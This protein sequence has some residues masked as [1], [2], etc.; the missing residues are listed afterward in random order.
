MD[1]R[2]NGFISYRHSELDMYVAKKIHKGLETFKVP[3]AVAKAT[4]IKK[5]SRVFRD[6]EELP[7]GSDLGDNI[8]SAIQSSEFLIVICSPRTP[9]SEWVQKE[10]ASFISYHGREHILAVLIE[11]EPGESFPEALLTDD[12][13]NPVEPLAADV[14]GLNKK[15]V[16]KKL[17]TELLRLAAPIL[18]CNYDDLRQRHRER[19]NRKIFTILASVLSVIAV[20]GIGFG[21]YY[22]HN[23]AVLQK[24]LDDKEISH[25]Q[26]LAAQSIAVLETGD[27]E[28]AMLIAREALPYEDSSKPYVASAQYALSK[29][30][31]SYDIGKYFGMDRSFQ[32]DFHIKEASFDFDGK[33]ITAIDNGNNVTVW[34]VENGD[35]L[36]VIHATDFDSKNRFEPIK[37][38]VVDDTLIVIGYSGIYSFDLKGNLV[39]QDRLESYGSF[40]IICLSAKVAAFEN[41]DCVHFYKLPELEKMYVTSKD[42]DYFASYV[43]SRDGKY[44]AVSFSQDSGK[45]EYA[46][47]IFD[48]EKMGSSV[49]TNPIEG[50]IADMRF[51][52]NDDLI[53]L[54]LEDYF[55][56]EEPSDK[57]ITIQYFSAGNYKEKWERKIPALNEVFATNSAKVYARIYTEE[58]LGDTI[59]HNEAIVTCN[60]S[61][62]VLNG[63]NGETV[64][65]LGTINVS[66][67]FLG[68]TSGLG[69]I[70]QHTGSI[71]VANLTTGEFFNN[72]TIETDLYISNAIFGNRRFAI[73]NVSS[74]E[75]VT[76][77]LHDGPMQETMSV[78]QGT[79]ASVKVSPKGSVISVRDY[80]DGIAFI[81]P[82]T[83][84]IASTASL[85]YTTEKEEFIDEETY[86]SI[87]KD[88][89]VQFVNVLD[90]TIEDLSLGDE[91]KYIDYAKI[92]IKNSKAAVQKNS[93]L[94]IID[95]KTHKIS[96]QIEIDAWKMEVDL[97]DMKAYCYKKGLSFAQV[98][99]KNISEKE[100]AGE[101][102]TKN[103]VTDQ[104]ETVASQDGNL[105]ATIC[106]DNVIRILNASTLEVEHEI[107]QMS[108]KYLKMRFSEDGRYFYY[109]GDD[110]F[111]KV[112]D[113]KTK[114][115]VLIYDSPYTSINEIDETEDLIILYSTSGISMISKSTMEL[116]DEA[117][118]VEL[119]DIQNGYVWSSDYGTLYR[120]KYMDLK[121]LFEESEKQ[122]PNAELSNSKRIKYFV[123]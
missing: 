92:D 61:I 3:S 55:S 116:V 37:A 104:M 106:N 64:T 113:L 70:V 31:Y 62:Y 43:A 28:A 123:D 72:Y 30:L 40:G 2:Y 50:Y 65:E 16:D 44:L 69:Y 18:H 107:K 100:I 80:N 114:Q 97:T 88:G 117:D 75:I 93:H 20:L 87:E 57:F 12:A 86:L 34:D 27:R 74:S 1:Y 111:F 90:G 77:S 21:L 96:E 52:E 122:F 63:E 51:N 11:G 102:F 36:L 45:E 94:C 76:L 112:Y 39:K 13:G 5:I 89:S 56:A 66:N 15:E 24:A 46:V 67:I 4:G 25:S 10:I 109:Q 32:A 42:H 81:K 91:Y 59:E 58:V 48:L 22:A 9:K 54:S 6:Q 83:L 7:I 98:D 78:S 118:S 121:A 19:R 35:T 26:F 33:Y 71:L 119:I 99:L 73:Y 79:I 115:I 95:L 120:F 68:A 29:S 14:R 47:E 38:N 41:G 103:D 49:V 101:E 8:T 85:A 23:A 53:V 105:V 84:E 110:K 108:N 60:N 17:K 82:D